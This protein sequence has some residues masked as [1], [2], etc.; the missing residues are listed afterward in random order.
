VT[1]SPVQVQRSVTGTDTCTNADEVLNLSGASF[2]ENLFTAVGND[3]KR[4]TL[5]H[6]GTSLTQVYTIDPNGAQTVGGKSTIKMTTFGEVF[7]IEARGGNWDIISHKTNTDWVNAG[8]IVLGATTTA[9]TMAT[10][11][12][13]D[14]ILWRRVG[15][16]AEIRYEY[17]AVSATGA[18]AGSGDY[19][20]PMPAN[21]AIDTSLV[22]AY[23]TAEGVGGG[24]AMVSNVGGFHA[25]TSVSGDIGHVNVYDANYL[26]AAIVYDTGAGTG[27]AYW[28]SGELAL[29]TANYTF[30][31]KVSVPISGWEP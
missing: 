9:P 30:T 19:K 15:Q 10:T 29:N 31:A 28:G 1:G 17:Q 23:T 2:T 25:S 14:R 3:G 20:I 18:T 6:L 22:T 26:R 8:N 16:N 24:Y 4:L 21:M 13:V 11:R 12:E 27:D 5:K 7:V